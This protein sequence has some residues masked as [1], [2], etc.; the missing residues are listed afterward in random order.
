MYA[1]LCSSQPQL[2]EI[3]VVDL[4]GACTLRSLLI[5]IIFPCIQVH[6]L[7]NGHIDVDGMTC[8]YNSHVKDLTVSVSA[9]QS[10]ID[11]VKQLNVLIIELRFFSTRLTTTGLTQPTVVGYGIFLNRSTRIFMRKYLTCRPVCWRPTEL[12]HS[13]GIATF[14]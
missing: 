1:P 9:P 4:G 12:A 11:C 8:D 13:R 14:F 5:M 7:G 3:I 2:S 10:T 6:N